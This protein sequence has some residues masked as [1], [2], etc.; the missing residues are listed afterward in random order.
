MKQEILFKAKNET[1]LLIK[2]EAE[3]NLLSIQNTE[4]VITNKSNSLI[5]ILL[6]ILIVLFGVLVNSISSDKFDWKFQ[7]S[8]LVSVLLGFVVY[9][10]YENILPVKSVIQGSEPKQLIQPDM[11]FGEQL[12]DDR[13]ILVNR[14]YSLQKAINY[15]ANSHS[16]RYKRFKK[17]NKFLFL[18]LL[19]IFILFSL[20]QCFL[21]F[22]DKY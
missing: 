4:D 19:I 20:F 13:N 8:L 7:L 9:T 17:G 3:K 5:Q 1:L 10:L 22:Q 11:I 6:P 21:L 15:S 16:I 18:G 12:K 14:I 2:D